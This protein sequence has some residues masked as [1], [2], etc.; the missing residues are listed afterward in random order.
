MKYKNKII[1]M[2]MDCDIVTVDDLT[3]KNR[4]GKITHP[5]KNHVLKN[6]DN[7]YITSFNRNSKNGLR[8]LE[9]HSS[10]TI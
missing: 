5:N 1:R 8:F 6:I 10:Y 2:I 9:L 7:Y 3:I 4:N